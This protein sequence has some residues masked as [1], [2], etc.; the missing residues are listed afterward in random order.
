MWPQ[1]SQKK[2]KR[3]RPLRRAHCGKTAIRP[4]ARCRSPASWPGLRESEAHW[5]ACLPASVFTL[6]STGPA[7][8]CRDA[9]MAKYLHGSTCAVHLALRQIVS[10]RRMLRPSV[11]RERLPRVRST[12]T[13]RNREQEAK[14]RR[15]IELQFSMNCYLH[16]NTGERRRLACGSDVNHSRKRRPVAR[17]VSQRGYPGGMR[18]GVKQP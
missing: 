10:K 12:A 11:I 1:S 18:S 2:R 14:P 3:S 4:L 6:Q 9:A 8:F 13:A 17:V 16:V 15:I 5:M 7:V